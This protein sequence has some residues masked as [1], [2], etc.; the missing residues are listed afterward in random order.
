MNA[1]VASNIVSPGMTCLVCVVNNENILMGGHTPRLTIR[2]H[3]IAVIP[4]PVPVPLC[5]FL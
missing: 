4:E 3:Y 5:N 2:M 1:Y